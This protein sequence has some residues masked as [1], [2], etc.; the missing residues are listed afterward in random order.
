MLARSLAEKIPPQNITVIDTDLQRTATEFY[1]KATLKLTLN[2]FQLHLHLNIQIYLLFNNLLN[3]MNFDQD[4]LQ[5]L[6]HLQVV[7]RDYGIWLQKVTVF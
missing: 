6:I 3:K 2:L 5:L 4:M 1:Q 7:H